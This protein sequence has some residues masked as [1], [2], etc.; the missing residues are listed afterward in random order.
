[1]SV[2]LRPISPTHGS[3]TYGASRRCAAVVILILGVALGNPVNAGGPATPVGA[4]TRYQSERAACDSRQ[5]TEDRATC[6]REAAAVRDA[7][8]RG[9]L[10]DAPNVYE[11]N[12]LARCE[13]LPEVDRDICRRRTR[14]EGLTTG[15]VSGG[16]IFR[17]YREITLPPIEPPGDAANE[18]A[19]INAPE[20]PGG[21]GEEGK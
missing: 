4:E 15:S 17:E 14:G 13:A 9:Q 10:D 12:M 6:L 1:M 8:R 7:G 11:R 20:N 16:G 19:K 3:I 18:P 2:V 21:R 5:S